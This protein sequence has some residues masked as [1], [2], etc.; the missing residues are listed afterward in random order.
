MQMSN[1]S[2]FKSG[3][4]NTNGIEIHY[5]E[6]G[7]GPLVIFCHGWPES[8]YSWRHQLRAIGSAGYRAVALHMRGYGRSSRPENIEAYSITNLVG[9]VAGCVAGLGA[10][11][12]VVVGHDWGG[13]VAWYSALMRPDLFRG[14]AVLSVPFN[15][16]MALPPEMSI[17][18]L[19]RHNAGDREYYRLFFQEPGVAEADF[20]QDV[21]RS[22]L[23][24]LYSIS[25]DIV[26][27]GVHSGGWDGHFPKGETMTQQFVVPDELPQWLTEEDVDVYVQEHTAGG[28]TGGFNWYRNIKRL[29]G[30]TAPFI[31]K[32]IDQPSLYMYGEYDMIAGNRPE[33]IEAMKSGLSDLRGCIKFDGAGHW[34]QQE[35]ATGVNAELIAFLDSL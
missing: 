10:S 28:F 1:S 17:N 23:G 21:R 13:P 25:G 8:W 14:V 4:V 29:P 22:V 32:T 3:V 11:E 24:V 19:M 16:P 34:L 9:D 27:D 33:A 26:A 35:R 31:G 20:E 12:A 15:P 7:E 18:D 6:Y 2:D 30:L 5:A